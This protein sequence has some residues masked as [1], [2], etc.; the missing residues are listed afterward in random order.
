MRRPSPLRRAVLGLA[1]A[2]LAAPGAGASCPP[3]PAW[4][5]FRS[6]FVSDGG[7][8]TDPAEGA[9]QTTSEGQSYGLFFALAANDRAG[10]ERILRWTEDNLA[11][12]DLTARLP[13][14]QWGRRFDGS[15]G[16]LDQ[17]AASDADLWIA[18][19]LAEAGRLWRAPQYSALAQLLAERILREETTLLPGLGRALL[20]GPS[21]FEPK[22][23][24]YRLNPSYLPLQL[25]RRM[26][27]LFPQ[28]EWARMPSVAADILVRSAPQGWAPDWVLYQQAG[29]FQADPDS[30]A[31]GSYNAIRVYLWAG[32]LADDEPLRP[33]LVKTLAP[34]A[35]HTAEHGTPPLESATRQGTASGVGPAGFSAA[36]LPFLA[37]SRQTPALGQ[38]R[39]RVTAKAP[40]VRTDNY[41]DQVLTLFG[42]GWDEAR[43]RFA[44]DGRLLP[45]WTCAA[46]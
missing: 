25:L 33:V 3:W 2:A 9:G 34:M 4:D 14:W 37:A 15:W 7:R 30:K 24:L 8:V 28:S 46:N 32:M 19:A 1:L 13:A 10:F 29:G 43:F 22:P 44:R 45:R 27:A 36:L 40:L 5:G 39:L 41:Y 20:P 26:A 21:G 38:Q 35:R 18:Y 16:V 12:G 6:S 42:A 11:G 17:N 23:G 31:A